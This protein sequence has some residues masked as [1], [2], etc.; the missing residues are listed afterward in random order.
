MNILVWTRRNYQL[1]E[2]QVESHQDQALISAEFFK[3][4]PLIMIELFTNLFNFGWGNRIVA[5]D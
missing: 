3:S 4:A 1:E 5:N 2:L